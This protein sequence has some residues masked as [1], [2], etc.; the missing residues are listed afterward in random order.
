MGTMNG[1]ELSSDV[2]WPA[3][4]GR[5]L[6]GLLALSLATSASAAGLQVDR[7][8]PTPAGET[9]FGVNAPWYRNTRLLSA[10]LTLD[11]G[12][13]VIVGGTYDPDGA[14]HQTVAVI[15]TQLVGHVDLAVAPLDWLLLSASLPV[16]LMEH[17]T[18]AF[19]VIPLD[20]MAVGDPRLGADV[21]IFGDAERDAFSLHLGGRL[22]LP[23][24]AAENHAGDDS[25][26]GA[27]QA[28]IGGR[29]AEHFQ[30]AANGGALLRGQASLNGLPNGLGSVGSELQA[31]GG[32]AYVDDARHFD[33]AAEALFGTGIGGDQT[34]KSNSHLELLLDGSYTFLDAIKVGPGI[35]FGLVRGDGTPSVR[36]L[37]RIAYVSPSPS[38]H[39]E[40]KAEQAPPPPAPADSDGDRVPDDRDQCPSVAAGE[41]PDANRPGCPAPEEVKPQPPQDSDGDGVPDTEDACPNVAAGDHPDANRAGCPAPVEEVKPAPRA[42]DFT[43]R[44]DPLP[45]SCHQEPAYPAGHLLVTTFFPTSGDVVS[46]EGVALLKKLARALKA[47]PSVRVS[48]D[49]YTDDTGPDDYNRALAQRR[50]KAAAAVLEAAG[51]RASRIEVRGLGSASPLCSGTSEEERAAERRAEVTLVEGP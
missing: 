18:P 44:N 36:G 26:R 27:L 19:G 43:G 10:G 14:F 2:K 4:G 31:A 22:W 41:T 45:A 8:E 16:T 33:V 29:V 35:G 17:G 24:G 11:W 51:V 21:R 37:L 30:W 39:E 49:G 25:A 9:F 1:A 28:M 34:L 12:H 50:A 20:G 15:H 32:V 7:Y 42:L 5:W 47:A 38:K 3:R 13:D 48:V 46:A 23:I 40:E 6:V